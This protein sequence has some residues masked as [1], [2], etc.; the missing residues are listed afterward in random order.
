[1]MKMIKNIVKNKIKKKIIHIAL[2]VIKPFIIP[3]II[4]GILIFLVSSITDIL[5]ISFDD[6]NIDMTKELAYYNTT[7]E[8]ENDKEAVNGFFTSVFDF[9]GKI[10]GGEMCE[11]TDWPVERTLYNKQWIWKKRFTYSRSIYD[12]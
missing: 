12:T 1:M 4:I 7:Y 5:Y 8:K 9:I 3:I 10:F 11:E 6:D 2:L